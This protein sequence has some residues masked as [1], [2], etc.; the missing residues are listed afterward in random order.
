MSFSDGSLQVY[1]PFSFEYSSLLLATQTILVDFIS[2]LYRIHAREQ[3][4]T[5]HD[6]RSEHKTGDV[7]LCYF[8]IT[9]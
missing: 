2:I 9:L 1:M 3:T 4:N 6:D 7:N 5:H 8:S